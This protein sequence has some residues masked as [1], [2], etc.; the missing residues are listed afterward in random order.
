MAEP[1]RIK[2]VV[3]EVMGKLTEKGGVGQI[4]ELWQD[5]FGEDT[6]KHSVP[7]SIRKGKLLVLVDSSAWLQH[8]TIKKREILEKLSQAPLSKPVKEIRFRQGKV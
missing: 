4:R 7:V 3:E 8:L 6:A 5:L 1:Q 2:S